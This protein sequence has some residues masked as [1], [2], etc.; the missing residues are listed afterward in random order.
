MIL[1]FLTAVY[2]ISPLADHI[3]IN[4][5]IPGTP[6]GGFAHGTCVEHLLP[7]QPD[8]VILEHLPYLEGDN[9]EQNLLSLEQLINRLQYNF[10]LSSFPPTIFL[11]M[12]VVTGEKY[13]PVRGQA[14]RENAD[15]RV[16]DGRLCSSLCPD[17]LVGLPMA[18]DNATSAEVVT[19]RAAAHYGAASLSY[20][21]LITAL[22]QSPARGNL[23]EC[24]VYSAVYQDLVHPN[25]GGEMLIA[26]LL[27]NYLAGAQEHFHSKQKGA[28]AE[29]AASL[30]RSVAPLDPRS[31]M[32]PWMRCYGMMQ[33]TF[34]EDAASH[35]KKATGIDV[36]K[37]EGWA[38][39]ETDEG[40]PKPGWVSTIPGSELW[41]VIDTDFGRL[42]DPHFISLTILSSYEHMGQAEV[43]CISGCSCDN[44]TIDGHVP[45]HKHSV[46]KQHDFHLFQQQPISLSGTGT[47]NSSSSK[48]N[49]RCVIQLKVL[50]DSGSGEHKVKVL[51]LAIKTMVNVSA[52]L[53]H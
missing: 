44:S 17:N 22:L 12:H 3:L 20:T 48:N 24:Q 19:N 33:E 23:S 18:G 30:L 6:F 53:P 40:H 26:D 35:D 14:A 1:H 28:T 11:N 49:S 15:K 10:N 21:N 51:Q 39:V 38:Y 13:T 9:P 16:R 36:A 52:A 4:N 8:L 2:F 34:G 25:R 43:T 50:Q 37:A 41:M 32:V 42:V 46:P 7:K 47:N 31:L 27:V 5:G 45:D 29:A